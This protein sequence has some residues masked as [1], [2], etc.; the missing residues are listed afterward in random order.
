MRKQNCSVLTAQLLLGSEA[1]WSAGD[2]DCEWLPRW[3]GQT[4]PHHGGQASAS[5]GVWLAPEAACGGLLLSCSAL[6]LLSHCP[7]F[8]FSVLE[9]EHRASRWPLE[10]CPRTFVFICFF[11]FFFLALLGFTLCFLQYWELN[12][13]LEHAGQMLYH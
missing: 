6:P 9:L 4:E 10:S 2:C 5:G 12:S 8:F 3:P 1:E 7:H 13:G 11:F